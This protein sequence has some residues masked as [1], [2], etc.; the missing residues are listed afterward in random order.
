MAK[1]YL[2]H[3]LSPKIAHELRQLPPP[4]D[5][6]R[7][8]ATKTRRLGHA[9]DGEQLLTA[10]QHDEI[11][12]TSN[13]RDFFLL[14]D[15]WLAWHRAGLLVRSHKGI[16]VIPQAWTPDVAAHELV[17]F[18]AGRGLLDNEAY[19]YRIGSGWGRHT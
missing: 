15:A 16:L 2:D 17:M 6:H 5:W 18:M 12:V 7:A 3:C 13:R 9:S 8:V 11:L 4:H 19:H 10:L 1:F 14:H